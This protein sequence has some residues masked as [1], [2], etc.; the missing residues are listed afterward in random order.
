MTLGT[1]NTQST[2]GSYFLTLSGANFLSLFTSGFFLLLS[3]LSWI[4]S[5]VAKD[6]LCHNIWV[7]AQKNIGTTACHVG[8]DS[9]RALTTCLSNDLRLT[10]MELC[11]QNV[12]FNTTLRQN[13]RNTLGVVNGNGTNKYWL[14]VL[15]TLFNVFNNSLELSVNSAIDQVIKVFTLNRTIRWNDLYRNVINLTELCVLSHCGTSHTGELVVHEEVVLKRNSC[16][17]LVLFTYLDVLFCFN[18]LVKTFGVTT[19]FHNTA[20]KLINNLNLT[21]DDNVLLVAMEHVLGLQSLLKVIDQLAGLIVVDVIN[22]ESALN[23]FKANFCCC[24]G[25]LGLIHLKVNI[26]G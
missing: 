12:M 17:S 7:A 5:L 23:L 3:C 8:C 19:T 4:N 9:N 6:I 15:M 22:V 11:I 13:A 10:F 21:I 20:G 25:V 16:Q 18:C 2:C 26:W 14:T 1:N 24:N